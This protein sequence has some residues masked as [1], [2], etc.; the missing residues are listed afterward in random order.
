METAIE[1]FRR[2]ER[3]KKKNTSII[4]S[5]WN[6]T[7]FQNLVSFRCGKSGRQKKCTSCDIT[8]RRNGKK[9]KQHNSDK[10]EIEHRKDLKIFTQ[11]DVLQCTG[12]D[13][14][15]RFVDTWFSGDA[16]CPYRNCAEIRAHQWINALK[17]NKRLLG[18]KV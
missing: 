9:K 7:L 5:A 1:L 12:R 8:D 14:R 16:F 6:I 2:T 17:S 11:S 4:Q 18:R 15:N 3:K 10:S 13:W